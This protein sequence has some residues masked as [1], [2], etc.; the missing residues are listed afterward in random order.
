MGVSHLMYGAGKLVS[1]TLI[2]A[3]FGL[4]GS[5][6]AFTPVV[7][8]VAGI[9]A[10]LFLILFGLKILNVIPVLRKIQFKLPNF[11]NKIIGKK[12]AGNSSPLVIG[13]LNGLMIACG[14]L[15][16]IYIMAAGQINSVIC[17]VN[18]ASEQP[19]DVTGRDPCSP[20]EVVCHLGFCLLDDLLDAIHLG[21]F[22]DF[23]LSIF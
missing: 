16:A 19:G 15:Q 7:R 13:L 5:I 12:T 9:L 2:G 18:I 8:G 23:F 10:G 21:C 17:L 11:V 3:A 22:H 20:V 6:I 14:P 1:Y 4:L